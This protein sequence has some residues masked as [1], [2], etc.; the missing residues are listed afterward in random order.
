MKEADRKTELL[1]NNDNCD[2][3]QNKQTTNMRLSPPHPQNTQDS[4][5]HTCPLMKTPPHQRVQN[6]YWNYLMT[7]LKI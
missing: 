7:D 5:S 2:K 3:V 1:Q 4:H 6:C